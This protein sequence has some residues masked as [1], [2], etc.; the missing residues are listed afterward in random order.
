MCGWSV[1]LPI[2][3]TA[4]YACACRHSH[5]KEDFGPGPDYTLVEGQQDGKCNFCTETLRD[6]DE[7]DKSL[8]ALRVGHEGHGN[9][10]EL[11][12]FHSIDKERLE[13]A[14]AVHIAAARAAKADYDRET[15]VRP[16]V[17]AV[18][19]F[20]VGSTTRSQNSV[21]VCVCFSSPRQ[22]CWA[23]PNPPPV[24]QVL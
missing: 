24:G 12:A 17:K 23:Q 3:L 2:F 18:N 16:K 21:C 10:A 4:R 5:H 20:W 11:N 7:R 22:Q 8:R 9:A 1:H 19:I 13:T 14:R 6:V 15:A